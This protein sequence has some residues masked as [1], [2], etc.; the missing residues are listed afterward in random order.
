MNHNFFIEN[1]EKILLNKIKNEIPDVLIDI[2]F[3]Y[4]LIRVKILLNKNF[5]LQYH[6]LFYENILSRN[7]ENFIRF[8]IR[9]NNS[10]AFH[11]LLTE[12]YIKWIKDIKNY[13]FKNFIYKNYIY[14]LKDFCLFNDSI[15]CL[16]TLNYF[17]NK[18]NL[19]QNQSKKN[20]VRN[21]RWKI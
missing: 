19:C 15:Q 9:S 7:K 21:I 13:K 2:V 1:E 14:F 16:N 6:S 8:I 5:Y 17:L 20:T 11:Q 4:I 18:H 3:Q 12:H 10:F